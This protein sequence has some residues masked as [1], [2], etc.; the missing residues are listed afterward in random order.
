M[1]LEGRFVVSPDKEWAAKGAISQIEWEKEYREYYKLLACNAQ[2]PHVKK[3][4]KT[5]HNYVFAGVTVESAPTDDG[6]SDDGAEQAIADAMRRFELGTDPDPDEASAINDATG[7]TPPEPAP[8]AIPAQ[9]EARHD[10]EVRDEPV[11]QV[12]VNNAATGR[13][14][15]VKRSTKSNTAIAA[16]ANGD[17]EGNAGTGRGVETR[18]RARGR[19]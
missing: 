19:Q 16:G 8:A 15:R 9:D 10:A 18:R 3:I 4:F 11:V 5:I 14:G 1:I 7:P 2:L 17:G 12:P 6:D 13:G